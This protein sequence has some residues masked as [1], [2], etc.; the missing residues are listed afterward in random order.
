MKL[1]L[2][3]RQAQIMSQALDLYARMGAGH[4]EVLREYLDH[5][6]KVKEFNKLLPAFKLATT[7]M[8][9][10]SNLGIHNK[11]LPDRYRISYDMH[12]VVRHELWKL[13][14]GDEFSVHSRE[15]YKTS[16]VK[17]MEVLE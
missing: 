4:L 9:S 14:E 5:F 17:L 2:S 16:H 3:V 13:S 11:E 10:G 12:Q 1:K 8:D 6:G 15:P 7:G